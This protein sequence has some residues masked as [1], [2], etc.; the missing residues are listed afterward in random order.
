VR[1]KAKA[2]LHLLAAVA[3]RRAVT[4]DL[5]MAF[6]FTLSSLPK[7]ARPPR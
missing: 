4:R 5:V 6:D 2:A 3:C 7:L 1:V